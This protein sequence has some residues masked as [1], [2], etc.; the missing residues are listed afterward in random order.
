ML[1]YKAM[2]KGLAE[3]SVACEPLLFPCVWGSQRSHSSRYISGEGL[4][5]LKLN[6]SLVAG[7]GCYFIRYG[8]FPLWVTPA[9]VWHSCYAIPRGLEKTPIR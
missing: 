4:H 1:D 2:P 5:L 3:A 9:R 6:Q 8:M 7:D